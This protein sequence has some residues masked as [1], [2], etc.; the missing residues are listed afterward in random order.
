[1]G[2]FIMGYHYSEMFMQG[3][4]M[5]AKVTRDHVARCLEAMESGRPTHPT[6]Y[7]VQKNQSKESVTTFHEHVIPQKNVY[8]IR[9]WNAVMCLKK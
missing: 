2:S 6:Q 5:G 3:A 1:M 7:R 9:Q 4:H 8:H